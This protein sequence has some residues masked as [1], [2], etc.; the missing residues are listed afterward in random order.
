MAHFGKQL[1]QVVGHVS[2]GQIDSHDGVGKVVTLIDGHSVGDTITRVQDDTSGSTRGIEGQHGL[3]GHVE[4]GHVEGLEED[5]GHLLSVLLGV[6]WGL[7]QVGRVLLGSDSELVEEAVMPDLLHIIPVGDDTVL[8]G[9][10]QGQNTSLGLGLLTD[11]GVLL[12]HADHD[13]GHLGSSDDGRE[14]GSWGVVT[15]DT[16][17]A[18][19]RTI[20]NND[21]G[22]LFFSHWIGI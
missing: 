2:S 4:G 11:I 8:N 13:A 9:V 12:V 20:V 21:S 18:H 19:T 22:V 17:F 7:S 6:H 3:D 1:D 15:G 5:L 16:S 10:F 14:G